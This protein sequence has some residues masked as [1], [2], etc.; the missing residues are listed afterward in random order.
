M[1]GLRGKSH[2]QTYNTTL[3]A[4]MPQGKCWVCRNLFSSRIPR[5]RCRCDRVVG[6]SPREGEVALLGSRTRCSGDFEVRSVG[7]LNRRGEVLP[8][9]FPDRGTENFLRPAI[10][11]STSGSRET[12]PTGPRVCGCLYWDLP[13]SRTLGFICAPESV[14]TQ[15]RKATRSAAAPSTMPAL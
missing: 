2:Y 7:R 6:V 3:F 15:G 10:F 13:P 4:G 5:R 12:P 8:G 9:R 11:S 1:R 14:A